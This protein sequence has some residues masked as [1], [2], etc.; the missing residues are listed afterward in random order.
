M[1]LG[2]LSRFYLAWWNSPPLGEFF[3]S[4]KSKGENNAR[5]R[6][7]KRVKF[8]SPRVLLMVVG[9]RSSVRHFHLPAAN[10]S[11]R[12]ARAERGKFTPRPWPTRVF[13]DP[14]IGAGLKKKKEKEKGRGKLIGT[15]CGVAEETN[16][17]GIDRGG[18][19]TNLA[20]SAGQQV[21]GP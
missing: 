1:V 12:V 2:P 6:E 11:S 21:S 13:N 20:P 7:R 9:E 10:D 15:R 14:R 4:C 8:Y 18:G 5:E 16:K 17:R 19:A 3:H